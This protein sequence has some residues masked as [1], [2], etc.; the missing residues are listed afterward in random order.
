ME[1]PTE[2][3]SIVKEFAKP[4]T[5]ADWKSGSSN[6]KALRGS[7]FWN[8]FQEEK[9]ATE[10]II[11]VAQSGGYERTWANW[12]YYKDIISTNGLSLQ[13]KM[14]VGVE[15]DYIGSY[16]RDI[17]FAG[18]DGYGIEDLLYRGWTIAEMEAKKL[19]RT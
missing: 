8:D 9:D 2:L 12:C 18:E 5:R 11:A 13:E 17:L 3:A 19:L 7:K 10:L 1:L 15:L 16:R 14:R 6:I 4:I